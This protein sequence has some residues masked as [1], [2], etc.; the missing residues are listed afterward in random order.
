MHVAHIVTAALGA[1]TI[2]IVS[3]KTRPVYGFRYMIDCLCHLLYYILYAC[4]GC[5]LVA[6][7]GSECTGYLNSDDITDTDGDD[8]VSSSNKYTQ[9][10]LFGV[11]RPLV[12]HH[13][14]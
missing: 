1:V 5:L 7:P 9:Y 10:R 13:L 2:P 12:K 14:I 3:M 6:Y 11:R 4:Q 8:D